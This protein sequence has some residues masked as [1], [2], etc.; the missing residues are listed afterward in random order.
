MKEGYLDNFN[1]G[2][3]GIKILYGGTGRGYRG[4]ERICLDY[5]VFGPKPTHNQSKS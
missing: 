1:K 4:G 3:Y 2:N 5:I